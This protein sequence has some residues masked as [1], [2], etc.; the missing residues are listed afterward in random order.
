MVSWRAGKYYAV[1]LHESATGDVLTA[2]PRM[3]IIVTY[4]IWRGPQKVRLEA[5]LSVS[6]CLP[7]SLEFCN[8]SA[9][10]S[11]ALGSSDGQMLPEVEERRSRLVLLM[12]SRTQNASQGF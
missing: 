9:R 1:R 2:T 11:V 6:L 3:G 7:L 5:S 10:V 8:L 12:A 4:E